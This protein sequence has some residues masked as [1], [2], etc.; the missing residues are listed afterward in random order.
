[1]KPT[2]DTAIVFISAGTAY[3]D[4][5]RRFLKSFEDLLAINSLTP[6]KIGHVAP[7]DSPISVVR[8][9]L[10]ASDGAVIVA[11]TRFEI[12]KG[13]EF[14]KS[15]TKR[16]VDGTKLPTMWNQ[17]EGGIAYG[18]AI[19]ILILVENGLDRQG[20][21]AGGSECSPLEIEL[22]ASAFEDRAFRETF[23]SW[24][25]RVMARA[26]ERRHK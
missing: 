22:S 12:E 8:R 6:L 25:E 17:L 26:R 1:M 10:R 15:E 19:P 23:E 21:L 20:I 16:S 24:K 4:V 13:A 14:P 7:G 5:Q 11:F 2:S 9:G 3:T 18:L